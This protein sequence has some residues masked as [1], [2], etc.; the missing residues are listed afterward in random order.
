MRYILRNG[1]MFKQF[2]TKGMY[3]RISPHYILLH[4]GVKKKDNSD[5]K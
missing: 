2:A 1:L 3:A 5:E 4:S